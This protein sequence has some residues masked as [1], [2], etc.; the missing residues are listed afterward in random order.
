MTKH[1]PDFH[2]VDEPKNFTVNNLFILV[3]EAAY[4]DLRIRLVSHVLGGRA[5]KG[6]I[7]TTEQVQLGIEVRVQL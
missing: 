1:L 7:I 5:L 6:E 3:I 4:W 2:H